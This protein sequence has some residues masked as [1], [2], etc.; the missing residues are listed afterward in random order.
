M[1]EGVAAAHGLQADIKYTLLYPVLVNNEDT[2]S[3]VQ[4]VITDPLG[5]DR[6]AELSHPEAGTEDFSFI[7]NEV[8]LAGH[9]R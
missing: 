4:E 5:E 6:Y 8:P 1:V 7:A 2:Y 9:L 3:L